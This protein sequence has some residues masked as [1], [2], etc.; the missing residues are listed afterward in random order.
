MEAPRDRVVKKFLN[1]HNVRSKAMITDYKEQLKA[2]TSQY[3]NDSKTS[4][5]DDEKGLNIS[6]I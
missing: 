4:N 3:I 2:L 6:I 5:G 1:A